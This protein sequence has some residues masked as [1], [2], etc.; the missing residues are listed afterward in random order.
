MTIMNEKLIRS[1]T[2][3]PHKDLYPVFKSLS[4]MESPCSL[5]MI[6]LLHII[7]AGKN[8][9]NTPILKMPISDA[10]LSY[11]GIGQE[12]NPIA[13]LEYTIYQIAKSPIRTIRRETDNTKIWTSY[14]W[15]THYKIK[16]CTNSIE[17]HFNPVV[18]KY[19]NL[20]EALKIAKP[21]SCYKLSRSFPMWLYVV[22]LN[23]KTHGEYWVVDSEDFFSDASIFDFNEKERPK[24]IFSLGLGARVNPI[25]LQEQKTALKE[26]RPPIFIPYFI[27]P[28]GNLHTIRTK[29]ELV[30]NL[31]S[32]KVK[33]KLAYFV[34]S[35]RTEDDI[36]FDP[37]NISEL[38]ESIT[39]EEEL[40]KSK[41][42]KHLDK[43][44]LTH[45]EI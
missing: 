13:S 27:S 4:K 39:F 37:A 11:L 32:I 6:Y 5:K 45:I 15:L 38:Q 42:F 12:E 16:E 18:Q 43:Y 26:K 1:N 19:L 30:V 31:C 9:S 20:L 33:N 23:A 17:I 44:N 34:F 29:S 14:P 41:L 35:F 10:L 25:C 21:N 3:L 2:Y 28:K 22:L 7:T 8:V 36:V 40:R 24:K